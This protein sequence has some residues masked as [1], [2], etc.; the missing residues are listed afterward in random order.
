[1]DG[2]MDVGVER[3]AAR[4]TE[5]RGRRRHRRARGLVRREEHVEVDFRVIVVIVVV[6]I[7]RRPALGKSAAR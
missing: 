4:T 5:G 1:M 2:Q 7:R 3:A 6:V